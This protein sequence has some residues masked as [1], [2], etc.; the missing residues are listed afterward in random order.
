PAELLQHL[1]SKSIAITRCRRL[2]VIVAIEFDAEQESAGILGIH[3]TDVNSITAAANLRDCTIS[4]LFQFR[5][6]VAGQTGVMC[7]FLNIL[8]LQRLD[9]AFGEVQVQG[10]VLDAGSLRLGSV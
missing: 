6:Y 5:H 2:P 10:Q 4:Q 7:L 8:E 9:A 3:Y 1:T